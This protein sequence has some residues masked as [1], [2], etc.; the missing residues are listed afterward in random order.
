MLFKPLYG[1]IGFVALTYHWLFECIAPI[2][3]V[4]G[5]ASMIAAALL[6]LLRAD[7]FIGFLLFGYLF[8][9]LISIGSVVLEEMTYHRYSDWRDLARLLAFCFLEFFPYRPLNALW[10][11]WGLWNSLRGR[12]T[13]VKDERVGFAEQAASGR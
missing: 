10:R 13:W 2:I 6:G 3:E 8:G 1:R 12:N 9:T 11:L 4:F 5:W 7:L